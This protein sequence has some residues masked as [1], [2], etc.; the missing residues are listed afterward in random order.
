MDSEAW[1]ERYREA[2]STEEGGGLWST[3][4]HGK[5]QEIVAPLNPGAALDLATGD[6]RNAV[7]LADR[8]WHVT[9]V[10]FSAEGLDIA[11]ARG[12]AEGVAIDWQLGDATYWEPSRSYELI[13][14]TYLHLGEASNI[15]VI[16]RA[17]QWLAPGGTLL[18]IGHDKE[19]LTRGSGGPQDPDI[20]YSPG[21]LRNAAEG[22]RII[23]AEQIVRN[24][25]ADPEGPQD[26]GHD[27]VDTLLHAIN[28]SAAVN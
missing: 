1:D 25:A 4:P 14:I 3:R 26:E 12:T 6:G 15:S 28:S 19:N 17:A 5:L 2:R 10:D 23:T 11:R 8:G 20:L 13:M 24:T 18:V 22:L 9:A 21:M 27:A 7:W 16:R